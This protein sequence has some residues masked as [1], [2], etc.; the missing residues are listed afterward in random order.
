MDISKGCVIFP[1]FIPTIVLTS[2][3]P[4]ILVDDAGCP[5]ITDFALPMFPFDKDPPESPTDELN[6]TIRWTAPEVLGGNETCTSKAAD[7]FSFAMVMIEV[8]F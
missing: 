2:G 5:R 1:R 8:R 7:V 3:Q 4:N 6:H